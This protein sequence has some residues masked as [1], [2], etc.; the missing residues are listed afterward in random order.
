MRMKINW[1]FLIDFYGELRDEG[2]IEVVIIL[3]VQETLT[4]KL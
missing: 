2:F 3:F 1:V 4:K